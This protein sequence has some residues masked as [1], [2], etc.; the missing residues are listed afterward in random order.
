MQASDLP[1]AIALGMVATILI[2]WRLFGDEPK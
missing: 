1:G 2:T